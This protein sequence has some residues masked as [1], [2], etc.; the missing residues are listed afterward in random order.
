MINP[1]RFKIMEDSVAAND[2]VA[3][4]SDTSAADNKNALKK[5]SKVVVV[6]KTEME[7]EIK[8]EIKQEQQK[9]E[10]T[11]QIPF[12]CMI[13]GFTMPCQYK[14]KT[15]RFA[16]NIQFNEECYLIQ[17]PFSPPPGNLSSKS[18]C[19][20]FIVIGSDCSQCSHPVCQLN[21]CSIFYR[22]T[23]CSECAYQLIN[24]FPAEV[25]SKIRKFCKR[26]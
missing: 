1:D 13:C 25:Q 2:D 16:K 19:E 7:T 9:I 3:V 23:Y 26:P 17:D 14:G 10:Q 21:S 5:E 8:S 18:T 22:K 11:P 24:T 20:H 12:T 6:V 15:P 4:G